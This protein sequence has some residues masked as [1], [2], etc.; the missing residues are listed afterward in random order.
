[1]KIDSIEVFHVSLPRSQPQPT[2]LGRID[3]VQTVL[4]RMHS[5]E[6]FGW[7]ES[8]PGNAPLAGPEW[9]AGVFACVRDWLAPA[10]VGKTV[11]SGSDLQEPC[12]ATSTPRRRWIRR[13]GT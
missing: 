13:G 12:G 4:V 10:V 1:M 9:A 5:G 8:S 7:G 2:R 11:T 6:A 3:T